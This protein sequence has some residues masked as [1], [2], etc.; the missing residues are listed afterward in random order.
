M[1]RRLSLSVLLA[2]LALAALPALAPAAWFPAQPV[3][4]PSLDIERLGGVDL[5]RDGTG[6]VVYL[7]R[8]D[9]VPHV[10]LSR[11]NGGQFRAPERVDNGIGVG[12]SEAAIAVAD[13]DRLAIVWIAGSRV[14][15]SL[16]TGSDRQPGPLLGPTELYNDPTGA[17][18]DVA[19][20]M[21]PTA[22]RT[23]PGRARAAA[24]RT[25]AARA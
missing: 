17:V 4:G 18:S 10:F 13:Q 1:P 20:D 15:G 12:A 24:A 6:G 11:F 21:G 25:S 9:G 8:V 22:P 16:V 23:P 14:Y 5:A 2:L 3:D 19:I 7:K